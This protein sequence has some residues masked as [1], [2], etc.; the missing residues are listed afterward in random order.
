MFPL[1]NKNEKISHRSLGIISQIAYDVSGIFLSDK[2]ADLVISRLNKR[3]REN[4]L[5][6][7]E[8]YCDLIQSNATERSQMIA[9][10]TTNVTAFYR[11]VHH[12][13][14][15]S[16]LVEEKFI[17]RIQD[18]E[19]LRIWSAACSSGEEVYSAAMTVSEVLMGSPSAKI[20]ILGTDIDTN[21]LKK[22]KIAFYDLEE[23]KSIPLEKFNK[24]CLEKEGAFTFKRE[25]LE[26]VRFNP[27]NLIAGWPFE[28]KFHAIFC[29]NVAIYFDKPTR[30]KLWFRLAQRLHVGG[31]IYI[32]HSERI[33]NPELL[34]LRPVGLNSYKRVK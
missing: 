14:Y 4:K 31:E 8:E 28:S 34:G 5:S 6:N 26:L 17:R 9:A 29:R 12:F 10:L 7:F 11:E 33:S 27:L 19:E 15:L 23:K 3:L 25:I 30:E 1:N 24:F 21:M 18:G 2:K 20:K 32:G 16:R 22:S 13:N